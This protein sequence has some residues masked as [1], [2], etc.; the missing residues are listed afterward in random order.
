M[1]LCCRV[2]KLRHQIVHRTPVLVLL[3]GKCLSESKGTLWQAQEDNRIRRR[4]S[5]QRYRYR[6]A[7]CC[8]VF[9]E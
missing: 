8:L 7:L 6:V 2:N 3:L 1:Y 9:P 4:D 5:Q